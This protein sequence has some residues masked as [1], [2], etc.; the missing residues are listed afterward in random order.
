MRLIAVLAAALMLAACG[1]D[2]GDDGSSGSGSG[3]SPNTVAT[4][5]NDRLGQKVLVDSN[6]MTLYTLS[7]EKGGRFVCTDDE[8]LSLW[9][10]LV[11]EPTGDVA[12]LGTVRR[13]DGRQQVTYEDAPLYT[14]TEDTQKG[15]AKGEGF[16][17]VGVWRAATV[18]GE[19][20]DSGGGGG[21]GGGYGGY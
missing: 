7:E 15:D 13:P 12:G 14:F 1:S 2:N 16:E 11:G 4:A 21:G 3:G 10:P 19:P 6:G 17:D 8:C 5:D 20:P 9:A 18:D